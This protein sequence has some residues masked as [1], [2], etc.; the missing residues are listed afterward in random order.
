MSARRSIRRTAVVTT[1]L[2]AVGTGAVLTLTPSAAA[3]E[4]LRITSTNPQ[5]TDL[6]LGA[7]G[8]SAGDTQVFVDEILR[9]GKP[10]GSSSGMCTITALS[11]TQLV[12]TCTTTLM[13][14]DGSTLSAQGAGVENLQE[15]PSGYRWAV[16]GGTG[17][18]RGA[19]GEA[20]GTFRPNSDTVDIE[21][22]LD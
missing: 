20:V 12:T 19:S 9:R 18:Y 22:R 11:E 21:I 16:T 8:F 5:N 14:S 6:D 17:R 10:I 1:V 4:V 7:A 15:G 2:A 13:F 3:G